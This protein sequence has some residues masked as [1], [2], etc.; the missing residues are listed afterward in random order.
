LYHDYYIHLFI[1]NVANNTT[2][3]ILIDEI[4]L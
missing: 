3:Q 2:V 4:I 1:L